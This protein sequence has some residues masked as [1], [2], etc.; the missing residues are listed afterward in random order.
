[1]V[2]DWPFLGRSFCVSFVTAAS[3]R[4][5]LNVSIFSKGN[6][7]AVLKTELVFIC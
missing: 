5:F 2:R 7:Y 1:M 4:L 3:F 6:F